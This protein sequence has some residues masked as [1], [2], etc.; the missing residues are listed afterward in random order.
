MPNARVYTLP[1]L[2]RAP[3]QRYALRVGT[4]A[5]VPHT[6]SP[7]PST[8]VGHG[9]TWNSPSSPNARHCAL[10]SLSTP[11]AEHQGLTLGSKSIGVLPENAAPQ[12]LRHRFT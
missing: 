1:S 3:A 10:Y 2:A 6:H 8:A 5:G 11:A 4:V 7:R 9:F 12:H